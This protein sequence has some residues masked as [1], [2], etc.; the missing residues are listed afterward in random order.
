[1][2]K[3]TMS[4][5]VIYTDTS[6]T[7]TSAWVTVSTIQL[8]LKKKLFICKVRTSLPIAASSRAIIKI[9]FE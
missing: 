9:L 6:K 3:I 2:M 1:M 4:I 5:H 7:I 8:A